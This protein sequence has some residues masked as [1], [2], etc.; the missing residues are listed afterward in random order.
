M[1][2]KIVGVFVSLA[3]IAIAGTMMLGRLVFRL[4][5]GIPW[6]VSGDMTEKANGWINHF[7]FPNYFKKEGHE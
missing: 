4:V 1:I 3:V 7:L 5:V 6:A 2:G